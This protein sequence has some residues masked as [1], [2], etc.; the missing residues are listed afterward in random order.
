M[1]PARGPGPLR[2]WTRGW[3]KAFTLRLAAQ[4]A[5]AVTA[6][7]L[8]RP[9]PL[10][11]SRTLAQ[12]LGASRG[13]VIAADQELGARASSKRVD[14]VLHLRVD[15]SSGGPAEPR[16]AGAATPPPWPPRSSPRSLP[17]NAADPPA[18]RRRVAL[19]PRARPDRAERRRRGPAPR[20]HRRQQPPPVRPG[21]PSP[22][23]A[24]PGGGDAS[25][26]TVTAGSREGLAL[27]ALA[28][29]RGRPRRRRRGARRPRRGRR[30][31]QA[32]ACGGRRFP[33][34]MIGLR[35]DLLPQAAPGG[36]L[37]AQTSPWCT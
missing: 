6:G 7:R 13:V 24:R 23:G 22:R 19:G 11:A 35:V 4:L 36:S 31:P 20:P 29:R 17:R 2:C 27:L 26:I 3:A 33:W 18:A 5:A 1:R 10:P 37:V 32:G 9:A 25:E 28:R 21:G 16:S 8:D 34:T 30:V 15:R 14:G 12:R